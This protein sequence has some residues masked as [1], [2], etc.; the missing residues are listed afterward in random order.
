[1]RDT[2]PGAGFRQDLP[3]PHDSLKSHILDEAACPV[4]APKAKRS[5]LP[6]IKKR[7]RQAVSCSNL[8]GSAD[9]RCGRSAIRMAMCDFTFDSLPYPS[10]NRFPPNSF[11]E[12]NP[13]TS[14][15]C[16]TPQLLRRARII[17]FTSVRHPSLCTTRR[18]VCALGHSALFAPAASARL[19]PPCVSNVLAGS[20]GH[21]LRLMRTTRL[22]SALDG[23]Q[24][25]C[26]RLPPALVS[27]LPTA[28]DAAPQHPRPPLTAAGEAV[29]MRLN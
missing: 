1:M 14:G 29:L 13:R 26:D 16:V 20:L 2:R 9:W 7:R 23:T 10:R 25:V 15:F 5:I 3:D 18:R 17:T 6:T 28:L 19:Q 21:Q 24:R 8:T 11:S 4:V 12:Q 27:P 22:Y